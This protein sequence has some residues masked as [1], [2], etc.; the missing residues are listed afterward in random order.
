MNLIRY[1]NNYQLIFIDK[2]KNNIN[3]SLSR[4]KYFNEN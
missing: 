4:V 3:N 2:K 1:A